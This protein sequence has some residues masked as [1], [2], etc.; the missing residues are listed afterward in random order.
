MSTQFRMTD[1]PL[2]DAQGQLIEKGYQTRL[3]RVYDRSA[4]RAGALR[5]K[6]WDYYC[7]TSG[8]KVLALT[9]ADNSYM[10]LDSI[11]LLDVDAGW[12]HTRS[13][14]RAFPMGKTGLPSTSAR[15]DVCVSGRDHFLRFQND[16]RV[17]VLDAQ[18]G[19]F[20]PGKSL[21]AHLVLTDEPE[22]SMV[23]A[24]PFAGKP[25]HFYYNQKIRRGRGRL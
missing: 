9:I 10:G 1:G 24:T 20:Q 12:Q 3:S 15:G 8:S 6:E 21:K 13:I 25:R 17:R 4:I 14:M 2:L 5:I 16:G 7:V 11:S 22:D 19:N 18:M 23:I